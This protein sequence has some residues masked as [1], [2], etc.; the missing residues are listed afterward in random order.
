MDSVGRQS[1]VSV[2]A[3]HPA[4]LNKEYTLFDWSPDGTEHFVLSSFIK[5]TTIAP[6]A[7]DG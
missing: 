6:D 4:I 7:L 3:E 1:G 5:I 2:V